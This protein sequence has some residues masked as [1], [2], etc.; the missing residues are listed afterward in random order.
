MTCVPI[1]VQEMSG[2][3]KHMFELSL[4][5]RISDLKGKIHIKM[6]IIPEQQM[7]VYRGKVLLDNMTLAD[8]GIQR[9]SEIDLRGRLKGGDDW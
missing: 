5:D 3:K 4:N 7:L 8:H 9:D 2:A 6:G 1:F